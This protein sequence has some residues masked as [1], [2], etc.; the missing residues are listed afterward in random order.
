MSKPSVAEVRCGE[1]LPNF[2]AL[3]HNL[4]PITIAY[5]TSIVNCFPWI[6]GVCLNGGRG[7]IVAFAKCGVIVSG[8]HFEVFV[9]KSA[10]QL[11]GIKLFP[12]CWYL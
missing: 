3:N 8:I 6:R 12:S 10:D 5:I 4:I 11:R 1:I 2:L 9:I 7:M